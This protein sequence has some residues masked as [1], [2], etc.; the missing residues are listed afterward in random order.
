M[1]IYH[2]GLG[3][4]RDLNTHLFQTPF[5]LT[6]EGMHCWQEGEVVRQRVRGTR[7][8]EARLSHAT[9]EKLAQSTRT[10]DEKR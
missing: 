6:S 4:N 8:E 5:Q 2:A 1:D 3:A 10:L 9:T 7:G